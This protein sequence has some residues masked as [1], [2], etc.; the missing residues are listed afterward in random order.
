MM[1]SGA[2]LVLASYIGPVASNN[3]NIYENLQETE[4]EHYQAQLE[5]TRPGRNQ[6][7]TPP[8]EPQAEAPKPGRMV[9]PEKYL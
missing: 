3:P 1:V 2:I 7:Y 9:V 4:L 6:N 5:Y 8:P